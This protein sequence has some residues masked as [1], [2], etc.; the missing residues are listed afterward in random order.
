MCIKNNLN[1]SN[2]YIISKEKDVSHKING[3]YFDDC[4]TILITN[5]LYD[6]NKINFSERLNQ[7]FKIEA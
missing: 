7:N 1:R 2:E 5:F 3:L 4:E 6:I